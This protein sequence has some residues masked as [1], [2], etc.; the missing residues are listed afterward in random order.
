MIKLNSQDVQPGKPEIIFP[1]GWSYR[2]VVDS[3][4]PGAL[5][6]LNGVLEK[7]KYDERFAVGNS[8][9]SQRYTSFHVTLEVPSREVMNQLA[10]E[11]GKIDGVKFVL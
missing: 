2:V 3:T 7:F 4:V 11:F 5:T 6:K 10:G 8:S 1:T 9:S